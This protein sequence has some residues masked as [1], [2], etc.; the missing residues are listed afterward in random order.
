MIGTE[1][2]NFCLGRLSYGK[3][4]AKSQYNCKSCF[5]LV[6]YLYINELGALTKMNTLAQINLFKKKKL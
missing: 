3:K 1:Q 4:P 2:Q 5:H 6:Y